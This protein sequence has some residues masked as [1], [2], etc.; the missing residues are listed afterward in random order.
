METNN[1]YIIL[2]NELLGK[3]SSCDVYKCKDVS[4]NYYAI[5]II[6]K[7]I[8][9]PKMQKMLSNEISILKL[10]KSEYIMN[11]IDNYEDSNN[12][13]IILDLADNKFIDIIN[14]I[15]GVDI[16]TYMKQLIKC[17]IYIQNFKVSHN[18]IKPANILI[19]NNRLKLCDFG[20]SADIDNN[21]DFFC[22]SP[23]YMNLER[24]TGNY[25]VS[26]DF[27]AVK[28]IY[29]Y[30]VYGIMPYSNSR[31]IK[32]LIKEIK[33]GIKYPYV[34]EQHT[35]ILKSLFNNILSTPIDLLMKIESIEN[36]FTFHCTKRNITP[37]KE[38]SLFL[39]VSSVNND[40]CDK[41]IDEEFSDF[42]LLE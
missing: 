18:D 33:S 14:S 41:I 16:F 17:L 8:I 21:H 5:K 22:G 37:Y 42:L 7:K 20:M 10:L 40:D 23:Y 15:D 39:N 29:Y 35:D 4:D 12:Y 31:N 26:S 1:K 25:K 36:N 19:H 24:L 3:G 28:I 32:E 2:W 6:S 38:F 9:T 11:I 34:I 13:Y 27:W 30:M